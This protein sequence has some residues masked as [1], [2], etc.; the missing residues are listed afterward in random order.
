MFN[1]LVVTIAASLASATALANCELLS[2]ADAE[3]VRLPSP[4]GGS[5]FAAAGS[6]S[7][8]VTVG[9]DEREALLLSAALGRGPV[10]LVRS[11]GSPAIEIAT[12]QIELLPSAEDAPEEGS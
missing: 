4:A 5:A 9:I 7:A 12:A 10:E 2:V 11:T 6:R 1:R 8:W 3:V